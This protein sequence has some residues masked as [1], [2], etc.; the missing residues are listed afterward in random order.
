MKIRGVFKIL[1]NWLINNNFAHVAMS[2]REGNNF[3]INPFVE[4]SRGIRIVGFNVSILKQI[5]INRMLLM[6]DFDTTLQLLE[7]G[8]SNRILYTHAQA[9][10]KSNDIGGCCLYRTPEAMKKSAFKLQELHPNFVTVK[11]KITK[12]PWS[13]FKTNERYDVTI[14]W[15]KAFQ[16]GKAKANNDIKSFF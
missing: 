6:A 9:H 14:Q 1:E 13:G 5:K 10:K 4:N 15:K 7:L 8:Y 3:V 12:K 2:V 11:K 16:Y